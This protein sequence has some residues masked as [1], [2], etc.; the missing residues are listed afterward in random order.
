MIGNHL[1]YH[2]TN[3]AF[4]WRIRYPNTLSDHRL[5]IP[6]SESGADIN[7]DKDLHWNGSRCQ[8]CIIPSDGFL[9]DPKLHYSRDSCLIDAPR[10]RRHLA[11]HTDP[12]GD[13]GGT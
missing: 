4:I 7:Y 9:I 10:A 12:D 11:T 8:E 13:R 1:C 2:Y 6:R 3:D 5:S